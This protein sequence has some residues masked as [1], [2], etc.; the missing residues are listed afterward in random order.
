VDQQLLGFTTI[1]K[2]S[3]LYLGAN[4][5]GNSGIPQTAYNVGKANSDLDKAGY[6]PNAVKCGKDSSGDVYRAYKDGTC[7]A[8]NLGTTKNNQT[9]LNAELMIQGDLAKI[10]IKVIT[11]FTPNENDGVFFGSF[12]DGGPLYTHKFDMGMYH[13]T[14]VYPG[15]PDSYLSVYHGNCGGTC[16]TGANNSIPSA[17]NQGNGQNDTGLSDPAV[18]SAFDA[19]RS[20]PNLGNR[21]S[22][23]AKVET[24]LA[25]DIPEIPLYQEIVVNSYPPNLRGFGSNDL[26]WD[27][28]SYDWYCNQG[29]CQ[30]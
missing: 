13:D 21:A 10:G 26:V 6:R 20:D 11:P 7:I 12:S 9:R 23:Y 3:F 5:I 24:Q 14:L 27:Y 1:P 30:A 16:T 22:D 25:N 2:D 4:W 18:D 28:N 15:E 29:S 8:V 19:A 17:A